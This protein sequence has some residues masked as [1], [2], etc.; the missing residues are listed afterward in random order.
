LLASTLSSALLFALYE[1]KNDPEF[2]A[3]TLDKLAMHYHFLKK[4]KNVNML[5][6]TWSQR[7]RNYFSSRFHAIMLQALTA[8][9]ELVTNLVEKHQAITKTY[10]FEACISSNAMVQ[11]QV[12]CHY[13]IGIARL[14][15]AEQALFDKY[16]GVYF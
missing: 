10:L 15:A 14:V 4:N 3:T 7:P 11:A 6:F 2:D 16:A 1:P 12:F 8:R 13:F 9:P 5:E